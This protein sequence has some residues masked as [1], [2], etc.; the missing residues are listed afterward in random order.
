[1]VRYTVWGSDG[2]KMIFQPISELSSAVR[3]LLRPTVSDRSELKTSNERLIT[4]TTN[5]YLCDTSNSIVCT[6]MLV[7]KHIVCFSH[8]WF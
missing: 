8:I 4:K 2:E 6:C 7:K 3:F 5:V 1:M